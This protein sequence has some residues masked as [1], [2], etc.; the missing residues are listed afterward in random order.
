MDVANGW[1]GIWASLAGGLLSAIAVLV[2]VLVAQWLNDKRKHRDEIRRTADA[3][4]VEVANVRDA[5][6]HSRS[7]AR[8]GRYDLW[9][10]RHQLYVS[11]SL[12]DLPVMQATQNYYDAVW[13][14]R[15]WVRHG[16]I[17]RAG[18]G[19]KSPED[20][21]ALAAYQQAIEE[22]ASHLI[23]ALQAL[24][25]RLTDEVSSG[26]QRPALPN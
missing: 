24:P 7:K 6:V 4:L 18:Q 20:E 2:G 9:P 12:R 22:W 26:P 15:N 8:T 25:T 3:L 13:E 21:R 23:Q 11:H 1:D 19:P 16:S 14:L 10:L 17:S 5:A